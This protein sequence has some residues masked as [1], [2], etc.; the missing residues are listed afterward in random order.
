LGAL[1]TE[2]GGRVVSMDALVPEAVVTYV[3]FTDINEMSEA[4]YILFARSTGEGEIY[5]PS[6]HEVLSSSTGEPA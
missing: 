5:L 3:G 2:E 6:I 4:V 1:G